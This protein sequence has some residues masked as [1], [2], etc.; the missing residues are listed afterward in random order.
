MAMCVDLVMTAT[1]FPFKCF[2]QQTNLCLVSIAL[3]IFNFVV[4]HSCNT[5]ISRVSVHG[6]LKFVGQKTGVGAY[7]E[8]PFV[9]ITSKH[10]NVGLVLTRENTVVVCC[11]CIFSIARHTNTNGRLGTLLTINGIN[12]SLRHS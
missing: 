3:S 12:C 1:S 10:S 4:N 6:H 9:H 5:V 2:L 8:N 7:T 11:T